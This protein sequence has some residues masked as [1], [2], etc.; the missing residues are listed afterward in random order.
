MQNLRTC[1][2]CNTNFSL[3]TQGILNLEEVLECSEHK[4]KQWESNNPN[5]D[6]SAYFCWDCTT[7]V[8][9]EIEK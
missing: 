8:G 5:I 4:I 9:N 3:D 2:N 6:L 7:K 1:E